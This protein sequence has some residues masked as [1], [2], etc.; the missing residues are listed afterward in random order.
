VNLTCFIDNKLRDGVTFEEA[1]KRLKAEGAD[2]VGINC[3]YGPANIIPVLKQ[4]RATVEGPLAVCNS[5]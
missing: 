1:Y 2:V 4:L 5:F 3:G